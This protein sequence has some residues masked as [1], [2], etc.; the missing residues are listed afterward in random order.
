M[1]R[2]FL[3]K[4]N[5]RCSVS[6]RSRNKSNNKPETSELTKPEAVKEIGLLNVS[7]FER[8]DGQ[9]PVSREDSAGVREVWSPHVESALEAEADRRAQL[10]E[11]EEQVSEVDVLTPDGDFSHF[12]PPPPPRDLT[13]TESGSPVKPVGTRLLEQHEGGEKQTLFPGRCLTS[14]P[15]SEIP[16]E[17]PELPFLVTSTTPTSVSASIE[18]LLASSSRHA[19]SYGNNDKYDPNMSHVHLFPPL[20]LMNPEQHHAA[21][22]R[23]FLEPDPRLNSSRHNKQS[24]GT[25]PKKPKV[26]RKLNFEDEVTT[27]PVLGLRIKKESPELRR[28]REKSAST[29]NQ[30]LG[31]FIC[32]LCKEEYPDPF[33]LAQHKC[34][35]IVRVEYRCPE[36]DKVFSCP[37]NLASHRRWHKPRPVNNQGGETPTTK[38]QPLKEARGLMQHER[39]PLE[40]E[41]KENEL[42]RINTNQHHAALDS[43][44]IRREPSLLLLHSRSR[45]SPDSD[46][47]AP[48]HYDSSLHYRNPVDS[49]LDLQPQVR[50]ADSPPSSLLLLNGNPDERADLSQQ[51]QPPSSLPRA[52]L[53]FVQSLPEEEVYECRYCGKKFRRQAYLKKHLAAHEMTARASPPPS[54]YSQARETSGGQ[55]QVFLCHLC[56]ARFPSVEIR[57]KHRLWHAMRDELLAGALGGGGLR[58]EVFHTQGDESGTREC[59]QQQ[60]FTCKHCPSTFFSSPGLARHINKSHPTE[61]RQVMLLQM[62]VRP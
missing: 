53:P 28:Q 14:S 17:L 7:P 24:A 29:G 23:S 47:L 3:V 33:S 6:Y 56:G 10:P 49:C 4:R 12:F 43:A 45:D 9:L 20:T 40:M 1:P 60:I 8:T 39:Q 59:E 48:P 35:R 19:P 11:T 42:L 55:S 62:T 2:G 22:K 18:R 38:S 25:P 21:R 16:A 57:D 50:A 27:S 52:P 5:R 44:R 15:V 34:S 58:P 13:L 26:N 37:A 41:G 51:Q 61:N 46:S 30:P 31:E 32:Q 36:C 54:P